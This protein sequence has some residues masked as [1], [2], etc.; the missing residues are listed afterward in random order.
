MDSYVSYEAFGAVGDGKTDDIAAIAA[1]H[2]YAN[3]H[4]LPVRTRPDAVYYIG[5]RAM[6]VCIRT[7]TSFTTSRFLI[8][9]RAPEDPSLPIFE[10]CPTED[11]VEALALPPLHSGQKSIDLA[12]LGITL[13]A[14]MYVTVTSDERRQYIRYGLNADAGAPQTDSF[15]LTKDGRILFGINWD[16]TRLCAVRATPIDE[17]EMVIEGGHFETIA[18]A[19]EPR[20]TYYHRGIRI[21]RSH[22]TVRGV[23][24]T[25]VGEGERGAPYLGFFNFTDC[26]FATLENCYVSGHRIYETVGSQGKPVAMGSYDVNCD[27]VL[28]MTL[29][30]VRQDDILNPGLWGVFGSNFCKRLLFDSCVLS[31][32]DAHRGLRDYTIRNS[33][34][35]WQGTNTIGFGEML[36]ENSTCYC[37]HLVGFRPDYGSTWHGDL[38]IRNV[39][40]IPAP[41]TTLSPTMLYARNDGRHNFG[42][43]VRLPTHI[44]IEDVTVEDTN[45]PQDYA[46]LVILSDFAPAATADAPYPLTPPERITIRNL[47]CKSGKPPILCPHMELLADTVIVKET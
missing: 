29:R 31:R 15:V 6:P 47:H 4:G 20:L 34:I 32:T 10:V 16:Y 21:R 24:H 8:D 17:G 3:R 7:P 25:V 13:S 2:A 35:G 45:V 1:A 9:D 42:Y 14:D 46:G 18:N 28:G 12:A 40:W 43:P 22:T 33:V 41:H 30:G 11:K 5:G 26:A 27:S 44:L 19:A 36:I 23:R 38:T 37:E 39:R